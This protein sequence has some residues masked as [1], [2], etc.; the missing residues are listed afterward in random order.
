MKKQSGPQ[1]MLPHIY[2]KKNYNDIRRTVVMAI[3][4]CIRLFAPFNDLPAEEQEN[5]IRRIERSCFN[6]TCDTADIKNVSKS[7]KNNE[8]ITLYNM[9]SYR[10][11]SNLIYSDDDEGSDYLSSSIING[12]IDAN[13]VGY[14][15]S[16]ELR[17]GKSKEILELIKQRMSQKIDKKYSTYY[18]CFK[19]HGRKTTV[20]ELQTRALDEGSTLFITCETEGCSNKWYISS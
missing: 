16:T 10:V 4:R 11:Q 6:S 17:P 8:F 5:I 13:N 7:W 9:I 3:G 18:E 14:L 12:S 20:V 15:K 19:C 2:Y 1:Q